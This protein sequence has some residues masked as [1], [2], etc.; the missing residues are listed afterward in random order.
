MTAFEFAFTLFGL[1]L[2]LALTEVLGGFVRVLKARSV[3]ADE[4]AVIRIGWQTPLLGV[5][6]A[7]DLISFWL[8]AWESRAGIP[9][10]FAPLVFMALLAGTYYAAASLVF[11]DD[12]RK[13]PDLDDWFE[14]HK[15]Q[16]A[17]GIFA[18]NFLFSFGEVLLFGTWSYSP[19]S[20]IFQI[21]YLILAVSLAFTRH[22][23]QSLIV[24]WLMAGVFALLALRPAIIALTS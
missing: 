15:A 18:A 13:W 17:I 21:F 7:L 14:R 8:G 5:V 4:D 16:V 6:V 12:P 20:R 10:D 11:P 22:G 23:R 2:G 3:R 24:L 1:V 9:I 19:V